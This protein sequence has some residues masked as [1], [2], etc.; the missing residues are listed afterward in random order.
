MHPGRFL[1]NKFVQRRYSTGNDQNLSENHS[2]FVSL[3]GIDIILALIVHQYTH[4]A[5][6]EYANLRPGHNVAHGCVFH[7]GSA[8]MGSSLWCDNAIIA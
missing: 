5:A 4:T 6:A 1:T 3:V 8:I 7:F 2:F